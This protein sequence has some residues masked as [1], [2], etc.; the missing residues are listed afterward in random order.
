[1]NSV[2]SRDLNKINLE[3]K[4]LKIGDKVKISENFTIEFIEPLNGL[5]LSNNYIKDYEIDATN[6]DTGILIN[7]KNSNT[8]HLLLCDNSP[9]DLKRLERVIDSRPLTT[10]FIHLMALLRIILFATKI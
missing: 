3:G 5:A 6:I 7:D 4:A 8:N 9:Y 1:M 2:I 10:F